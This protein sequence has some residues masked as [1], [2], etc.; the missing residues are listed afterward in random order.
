[1]VHDTSIRLL[2][3]KPTR[4]CAD[5]WKHLEWAKFGD[6]EGDTVQICNR[7]SD[8]RMLKVKKLIQKLDGRYREQSYS[9]LCLL[10]EKAVPDLLK[11]LKGPNPS[12]RLSAVQ[13]LGSINGPRA[14]AGVESR[15]SD[16]D[17]G[18]QLAA[19]SVLEEAGA[20]A[21][22]IRSFLHSDE[23][24]LR[25][26]ACSVMGNMGYVQ[27][28]PDILKLLDDP[29]RTVRFVAL[30][31]AGELGSSDLIA[32]VK[33]KLSSVDHSERYAA[34]SALHCLDETEALPVLISALY[35][36]SDY[37]RSQVLNDL[38]EPRDAKARLALEYVRENDYSDL[39][40]KAASVIRQI[41]A[42][43]PLYTVGSNV[44]AS[45][46][47]APN[48]HPKAFERL[49]E[50]VDRLTE[51]EREVGRSKTVTPTQMTFLADCLT[52]FDDRMRLITLGVLRKI[53]SPDAE[54]LIVTCLTD[55]CGFVRSNAIDI[56]DI[57]KVRT[58][59]NKLEAMKSDPDEHVRASA[60]IALARLDSP[61]GLSDLIAHSHDG[62]WACRS[63]AAAAFGSL[64][65]AR[66][67]RRL[68]ELTSDPYMYVRWEAARSL[69]KVGGPDSVPYLMR[70]CVND[71]RHIL[72]AAKR[73]IR[74][75]NQRANAAAS[76][77]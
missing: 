57:A 52:D 74:K 6:P 75:I 26:R 39:A 25:I 71:L 1:M 33:S 61:G 20:C 24:Q 2:Y 48:P 22:Q 72:S 12:A 56:L 37:I 28:L 46:E 15:L 4:S 21:E 73:A 35:D 54:Q 31:S 55:A 53:N 19:I 11:A 60:I 42:K 47:S 34:M 69:G 41:D 50:R 40:A 23:T 30:L 67:I 3:T 49:Q 51:L 5:N 64:D 59:R 29:S 77:K 17:E 76:E 13:V 68:E 32:L 27:A 45:A 36:S 43:S 66:A 18:V 65:D 7:Q 10:G 70:L 63:N 62:H 44:S 16:S 14:I 9:R 58:V 8:I 38:G